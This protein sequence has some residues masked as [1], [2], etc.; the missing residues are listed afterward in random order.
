MPAPKLLR[1]FVA[2]ATPCPPDLARVLRELGQFGSAVKASAPRGLH[3]TL[4]FLGDT[5]AETAARLGPAIAQAVADIPSFSAEMI[6]M[7][8]FP[9]PQRPNVVWAGLRA[10]PLAAL[11]E[12]VETV[13]TNFGY[14]ADR[15][16]FKPHVTLARVKH[17]PPARLA[18]LMQQH[19]D[20]N[21]GA[22]DVTAVELFKSTLTPAGPRY[23]V[24][25]TARLRSSSSRG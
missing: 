16:P 18:E 22:F 7:G 17:Q 12:Q 6:G 9:N 10:V 15:L 8:A 2:I 13:A 14:S 11:F 21:W 1:T 3:C 20:T 23:D 24:L 5:A 25:A 4:R 19:A